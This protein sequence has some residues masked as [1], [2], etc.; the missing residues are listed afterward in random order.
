MD[1]LPVFIT[2]A[3]A[4]YRA[5]AE[6]TKA[7]KTM[8]YDFAH[9]LG[10]Y[11]H[12]DAD[13]FHYTDAGMN[14]TEYGPRAV[15]AAGTVLMISSKAFWERWKGENRPDEGA[16]AVRE[17][18]ALKGIFD[19]DQQEFQRKAVIV[20]LPGESDALI[21]NELHRVAWFKVT[22]I[23]LA[24]VETLL[25]RLLAEPLHVQAEKKIR[26]DLPRYQPGSGPRKDGPAFGVPADRADLLKEQRAQ[27][28][29]GQEPYDAGQAVKE[30]LQVRLPK[31]QPETFSKFQELQNVYEYLA[32][33]LRDAGDQLAKSG[34]PTSVRRTD[35]RITLRVER[36]G[37]TVYALDIM[38]GR[39]LGRGDQLTFSFN[40]GSGYNAWLEA[41]YNL[42]AQCSAVKVFNLSLL[43][44]VGGSDQVISKEEFF[45]K[46]WGRI[47]ETVERQV[48]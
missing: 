44:N 30:A 31:V 35:E 20:L 24:G 1:Q 33:S 8:V 45:Q 19:R 12:V 21:P 28:R 36:L 9:L 41:V 14:W 6:Q 17:M 39:G 18:D 7:W 48:R 2:W 15:E 16:G 43:S 47:I 5:S 25:R 40:G 26:P 27:R 3:H 46:L 38:F 22:S 42:E 34:F 23:D 11:V 13:L 10:N 37:R 4:D 29:S 32:T